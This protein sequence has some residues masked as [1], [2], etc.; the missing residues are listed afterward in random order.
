[1]L[2]RLDSDFRCLGSYSQIFLEEEFSSLLMNN[3]IY[4]TDVLECDV[5]YPCHCATSHF[6]L[7]AFS[8]IRELETQIV[9]ILL[10]EHFPILIAV[11]VFYLL[12]K[13]LHT[14][15]I[16]DRSAVRPVSKMLCAHDATQN[17]SWHFA[18]ASATC[19][20]DGTICLTKIP[21]WS[22][23]SMK[24]SHIFTSLSPLP[25]RPPYITDAGFCTFY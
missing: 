17:D 19:C 6:L 9:A 5:L 8:I 2:S 3:H 1:M 16:D 4:L 20:L 24:P 12:F 22:S 23:V 13:M 21:V 10:V 14:F 25:V 11:T 7:I 18:V 15:S